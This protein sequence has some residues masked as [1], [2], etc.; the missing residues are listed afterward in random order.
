MA[1]KL[2]MF[3]KQCSV[4][5]GT[6]SHETP[7]TEMWSATPNAKKKEDEFLKKYLEKERNRKSSD[8]S[9]FGPKKSFV[10]ERMR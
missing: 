1:L 9:W 4:G 7:S 6:E 8:W 10:D 3:V 5:S 2:L